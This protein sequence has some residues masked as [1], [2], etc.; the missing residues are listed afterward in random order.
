MTNAYRV[1][2][3]FRLVKPIKLA[4]PKETYGAKG[5]PRGLVYTP[6]TL[7]CDVKWSAQECIWKEGDQGTTAQKITA[8]AGVKRRRTNEPSPPPKNGSKNLVSLPVCWQVSL[9]VLL[10][11]APTYQKLEATTTSSLSPSTTL[12]YWFS[13]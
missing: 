2:S 10:N 9:S 12:E 1:R 6:N 13:Y 8:S 5:T 3:I 11:R 7:L 4:T